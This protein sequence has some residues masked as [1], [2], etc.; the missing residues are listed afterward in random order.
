MSADLDVIIR[1]EKLL[2]KA[3]DAGCT[4]AERE[5]FQAKAFE[6]IERHR[7]DQAAIGGH[8]AADD[9][10]GT[11]KVGDFNGIYG[12]VRIGIVQAVADAFD[13]A[14]FWSGY[15]NERHLKAYGFRSDVDRVVALSNRLLAD[16]DVR[17]KLLEGYDMKDT[18]RQRRGFYLGYADAVSARLTTARRAAEA[19]HRAEAGEPASTSAALVLVDRRRQV[20]DSFRQT[21]GNIRAASSINQP[22][23]YGY[24]HGHDAGRSADLSHQNQVRSQRA[25][26][27]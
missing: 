3:A 16:A 9:E 1:V 22:G 21:H 25:L 23:D 24:T 19:A 7:I 20:N 14:L 27:R 4:E 17:V 15:R 10:L 18:V 8:L 13:V 5:A 11:W 12:R 2:A 6:L 26:G